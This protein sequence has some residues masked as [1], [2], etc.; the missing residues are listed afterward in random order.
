MSN[1]ISRPRDPQFNDI[2]LICP[3]LWRVHL[4]AFYFLNL[5]ATS[6]MVDVESQL[7]ISRIHRLLRPLRCTLVSNTTQAHQTKSQRTYSSKSTK[8]VITNNT[9]A[10]LERIPPPGR[11][12]SLGGECR[13]ERDQLIE[14]SRKIYTLRDC[15]KNVVAGALGKDYGVP[16]QVPSLASLCATVMGEALNQHMEELEHEI[17]EEKESVDDTELLEA[18]E[19]LFET[20]PAYQR[21]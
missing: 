11:A 6:N 3:K 14:L 9:L 13:E 10:P 21:K 4:S 17:Q 20:I 12:A 18:V 7:S 8:F 1:R 5:T 15:F 19:S 16:A 2:V